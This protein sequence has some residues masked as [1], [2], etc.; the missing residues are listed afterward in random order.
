MLER[1]GIPLD[2]TEARQ[3]HGLLIR[4]LGTHE[5]V[6]IDHGHG[7]VYRGDVWLLC[8]DGLTDE[9]GDAEI[10]R[11]LTENPAP[12]SAVRSLIERAVQAGGR[13]NVTIA[14]ARI[15]GGPEPPADAEPPRPETEPAEGADTDASG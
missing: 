5:K 10:A 15:T 11:V 1:M 8:S 6:D 7:N 4:A 2:A 12:Q 3:M 9:L 13:D 14:L